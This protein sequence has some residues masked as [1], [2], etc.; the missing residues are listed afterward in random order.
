MNQ[1]GFFLL[2]TVILGAV[3][4]AAVS[5]T[6]VFSM[7]RR[8]CLHNEAAVTAAFLGQE[9]IALI[10]A[11]PK[12]VIAAATS[13][14]WLGKGTE[15]IEMNGSKYMV[16]TRLEPAED[17]RFRLVTVTLSWEENNKKVT[18]KCQKLV[19]CAE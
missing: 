1:K 10:E 13:F 16:E 12:A 19:S 15:P 17:V 14:D 6:L 9:Q 7:A 4:T 11:E 8:Q 5:V 18:Q 2:E 3:L